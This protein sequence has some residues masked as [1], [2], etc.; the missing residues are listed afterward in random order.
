MSETSAKQEAALTAVRKS[1]RDFEASLEKEFSDIITGYA[2]TTRSHV[3]EASDLYVDLNTR[4]EDH[5]NN[6]VSKIS[7]HSSR[8]QKEIDTLE[9]ELADVRVKMTEKLKEIQ[10]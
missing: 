7:S 8:I 2:T 3:E 10:R 1:T 9:K 6:S 5:L 4:L